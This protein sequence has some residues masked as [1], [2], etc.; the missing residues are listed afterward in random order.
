VQVWNHRAEDLW[1]LRQDEA[2]EHHLLS[3][4]IGLPVE[5]LAGPLRTVL[6]GS[7]GREH[8]MLE[9]VNRRGRTIACVTTIL[10]LLAAADGDG[11]GDGAPVRGAIVLMEDSPAET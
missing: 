3:L 10:P 4:D 6:S 2:V 8:A 1:G 9:A 11:D 7:S 5:Q